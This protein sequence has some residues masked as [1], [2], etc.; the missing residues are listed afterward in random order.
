[1]KKPLVIFGI[2]ESAQLA[3][4]YFTQGGDYEVV[5][6]T[7][8]R[9][10]IATPEFCG[11]P[12]IPFEEIEAK[13]PPAK[14]GMFVAMGYSKVN[15]IRQEKYEAAKAKGY[16]LPSYVHPRATVLPE[17]TIGDNTFIFENN[18]IQPFVAI[19][20]NVVLWSGN[21]IGHH[22]TI[23]D[24]CFIAS[25]VVVSGGCTIGEGCFLGVN[26]TLRDHIAIGDHCVIGAGAIIMADAA[27]GGVYI[28]PVTARAELPSERLRKI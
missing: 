15:R 25:H 13:Y 8:D 9:E 24:H 22:S 4:L 26:A 14:A 19:G 16:T 1:M 7:V 12:V 5:A 23:A 10:Y 20:N 11:L 6:F 21:H 17:V 3:W 27:P 2:A 18:V 28:A